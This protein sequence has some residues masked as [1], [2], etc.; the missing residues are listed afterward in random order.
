MSDD[1]NKITVEALRHPSWE[2]SLVY[3][4]LARMKKEGID[5]DA[6]YAAT[7]ESGVVDLRIVINGHEFPAVDFIER[8][9]RTFD[10]RVAQEAR[11]LVTDDPKINA[12]LEN[13][14][15]SLSD[16]DQNLNDIARAAF[17]HVDLDLDRD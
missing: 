1:P 14:H 13:L 10:Y 16:I 15:E 2:S 12:I 8:W 3:G 9:Q 7:K 4:T 11:R 17:P 5:T 6:V